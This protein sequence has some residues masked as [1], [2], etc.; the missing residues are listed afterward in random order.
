MDQRQAS[1]KCDLPSSDP[2]PP[3]WTEDRG[4]EDSAVSAAG[5]GSVV[6]CVSPAVGTCWNGS[7]CEGFDSH[8]LKAFLK[9][10]RQRRTDL[11]RVGA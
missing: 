10:A 2:T 1:S 6:C 11:R 7:T 4:D 3:P 9:S 5:R 8:K